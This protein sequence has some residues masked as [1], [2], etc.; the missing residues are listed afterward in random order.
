[1]TDVI[2]T[3]PM[4]ER[5]QQIARKLRHML[6]FIEAGKTLTTVDG[7]HGHAHQV[8]GWAQGLATE[9]LEMLGEKP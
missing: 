6:T 5:E 1:M 7:I 9:V 4:T 3:S 2:K 8:V